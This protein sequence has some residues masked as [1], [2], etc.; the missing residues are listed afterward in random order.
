MKNEFLYRNPIFISEVKQRLADKRNYRIKTKLLAIDKLSLEESKKNSMLLSHI[1]NQTNYK[2]F[3]NF[4]KEKGYKSAFTK[5]K[6]KHQIK[7]N[8]LLNK[9]KLRINMDKK[10]PN[11]IKLFRSE[12]NNNIYHKV[13]MR[14]LLFN[15]QR[16]TPFQ[17]NHIRS[18]F[19]KQCIQFTKRK[20]LHDNIKD[21]KNLESYSI[22]SNGQRKKIF[23]SYIIRNI[24]E[25]D[26]YFIKSKTLVK[27]NSCKNYIKYY[28]N[29]NSGKINYNK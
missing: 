5:I 1:N 4:I 9:K 21:E 8:K 10:V 17:I 11:L 2:Y 15:N 3:L 26:D 13:N 25:F 20:N 19:L 27:S 23:G 28:M 18:N 12:N 6:D 7:P 24:S 22:N 29:R 14:D 16:Q